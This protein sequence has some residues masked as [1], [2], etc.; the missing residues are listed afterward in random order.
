MGIL[1][2]VVFVLWRL[3]RFYIDRGLD[4]IS[5]VVVIN[6]GRIKNFVVCLE[7]FVELVVDGVG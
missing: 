3:Y 4:R 5:Y 2:N 1:R 6:N 7:Y